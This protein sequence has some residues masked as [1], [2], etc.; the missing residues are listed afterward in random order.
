M[1]VCI[2][3]NQIPKDIMYLIPLTI[4]E[5]LDGPQTLDLSWHHSHRH[6]PLHES[7]QRHIPT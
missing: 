1:L 3:Y 6:T 2:M 5:N 4:Y 7:S